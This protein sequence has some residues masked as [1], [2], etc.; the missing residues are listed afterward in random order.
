MP[1]DL[2]EVAIQAIKDKKGTRIVFLDMRGISDICNF[3]I[4]CS[5]QNEK[6]T[7]AIADAINFEIKSKAGQLPSAVEGKENGHWVLLDYGSTIVHVF[8]DFIRDYYAIEK[9]WPKAKYLKV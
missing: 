4:I 5:G 7:Q 3:Q 8:H 6:Q 1:Q 2:N 9:L